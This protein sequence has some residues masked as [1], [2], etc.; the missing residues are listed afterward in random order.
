MQSYNST[1]VISINNF[2]TNFI[3]RIEFG[4]D[5]LESEDSAPLTDWELATRLSYFLWSTTP[6]E[7]LRL[8]AA[9]GRSRLRGT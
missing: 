3:Y 5:A 7:E 8:L 4:E 6:D 1:F 2:I 9:R